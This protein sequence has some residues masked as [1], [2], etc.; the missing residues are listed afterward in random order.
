MRMASSLL[1]TGLLSGTMACA[2]AR[3][4]LRFEPERYM[5]PKTAWLKD[6]LQR[7]K[8]AL[9]S[10]GREAM[11][12]RS[13][14]RGERRLCQEGHHLPGGGVRGRRRRSGAH[15]GRQGRGDG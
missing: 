6:K 3:A 13:P 2:T 15:S 10:T 1:I 4:Q 9:W 8:W 11:R 5:T 14:G 7:D 12:K